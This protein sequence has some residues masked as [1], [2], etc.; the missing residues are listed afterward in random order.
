MTEFLVFSVSVL[1]LG[2]SIGVLLWIATLGFDLY[3]EIKY[4][5]GDY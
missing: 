5:R 3:K 4:F 1:V 2:V